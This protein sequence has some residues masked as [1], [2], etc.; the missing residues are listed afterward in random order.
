[1]LPVRA[2]P[3]GFGIVALAITIVYVAVSFNTDVYQDA[4]LPPRL[5]VTV[6]ADCV[7]SAW[8]DWTKRCT[9]GIQWR[10]RVVATALQ[11]SGATCAVSEEQ[12]PCPLQDGIEALPGQPSEQADWLP[13]GSS[14]AAEVPPLMEKVPMEA[15]TGPEGSA[16]GKDRQLRPAAKERAKVLTAVVE[17]EGLTV[18]QKLGIQ[19]ILASTDGWPDSETFRVTEAELQHRR[20]VPLNPNRKESIQKGLALFSGE[21]R[22]KWKQWLALPDKPVDLRLKEKWARFPAVQLLVRCHTGGAPKL[23]TILLESLEWF[24]PAE[25]ARL[26]VVLDDESPRDHTFG[27]FLSHIHPYP[28]IAFQPDPGDVFPSKI[29]GRS[30]GYDRQMW[31]GFYADL[32]SEE[33]IIAIVDDDCLFVTPVT[34]DDLFEDGFPRVIGKQ[35]VWMEAEGKYLVKGVDNGRWAYTTERLLKLRQAADFM[36]NFPVL[37]RRSTFIGCRRWIAHVHNSTF[38]EAFTKMAAGLGRGESYCQINVI[39]NY[40]WYFQR[41]Q[42]KWHLQSVPGSMYQNGTYNTPHVRLGTHARGLTQDKIYNYVIEGYCYAC[43]HLQNCNNSQALKVHHSKRNLH[44]PV[45]HNWDHTGILWTEKALG[46]LGGPSR[47]QEDH[48]SRVRSL[49]SR[50]PPS[51]H[52]LLRRTP[53]YFT[54]CSKPPDDKNCTQEHAHRHDQFQRIRASRSKH[55]REFM[56]VCRQLIGLA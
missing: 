12:R 47:S 10:T 1:M 31:S 5:T 29:C 26:V 52:T 44:Q 8:T 18:L 48:Y 38:N 40:A 41:N 4:I 6:Q 2:V 50:W 39:L 7:P 51:I 34:P 53:D 23:L 45:L 46:G 13:R 11:S 36:W 3:L 43:L 25:Y 28:R 9:N 21:M 19:P 30:K 37:I 32:Y 33:D 24:W 27:D 15:A 35:T 20:I 56:E 54:D 16:T 55:E 17:G 49:P 14:V 42:Y 22:E